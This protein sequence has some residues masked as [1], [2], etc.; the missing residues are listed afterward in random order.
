[1]KIKGKIVARGPVWFGFGLPMTFLY[2]QGA[3]PVNPSRIRWRRQS[4]GR[5]G[6]YK[7]EK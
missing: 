6:F 3:M 4:S 1:V 5:H 7:H 2:Y